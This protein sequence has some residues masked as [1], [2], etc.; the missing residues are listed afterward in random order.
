MIGLGVAVLPWVPTMLLPLSILFWIGVGGTWANIPLGTQFSLAVPDAY[1]S[2]LGSIMNFMCT[3]ISPLGIAGAGILI[4]SLDLSTSLVIMGCGV[5][6]LTPLVLFIPK[7]KEFIGSS[8]ADSG[9]F[10]ERHYPGVFE[11]ESIDER[12]KDIVRT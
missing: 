1:R 4:S 11:L 5:I 8:H 2:R 6:L 7:F 10:F 12:T 3:G 9:T